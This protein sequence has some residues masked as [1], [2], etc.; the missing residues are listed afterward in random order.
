MLSPP[1]WFTE[2]TSF[3]AAIRLQQLDFADAH[4]VLAERRGRDVVP[5]EFPNSRQSAFAELFPQLAEIYPVKHNLVVTKREHELTLAHH[6]CSAKP[7]PG[8]C[9]P[10][11]AIAING[12]SM[13]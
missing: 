10:S 5:R 4:P 11:D 1:V 3:A 2:A 8:E 12:L 13:A 7:R 6:R 9:L